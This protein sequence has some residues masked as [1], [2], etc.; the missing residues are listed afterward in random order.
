MKENQ[1]QNCQNC[2]MVKTYAWSPGASGADL[3]K[4]KDWRSVLKIDVC[5]VAEHAII[6]SWPYTKLYF[7]C[8]IKFL[9]KNLSLFLTIKLVPDFVL[10]S[11]SY[12]FSCITTVHLKLALTFKVSVNEKTNEEGIYNRPG[13]YLGNLNLENVPKTLAP[14][15]FS[16]I[17][18]KYFSSYRAAPNYFAKALPPY[19]PKSLKSLLTYL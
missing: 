12:H 2:L 8:W 9:I 1:I 3:I 19:V 7:S 11:V 5:A 6:L 14:K 13:L 16:S 10:H 17:K 15:A 4:K 18:E